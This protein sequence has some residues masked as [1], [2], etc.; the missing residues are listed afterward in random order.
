MSIRLGL[1][2]VLA[3]QVELGFFQ[4]LWVLELVSVLADIPRPHIQ[5]VN[6]PTHEWI[7]GNTRLYYYSVLLCPVVSSIDHTVSPNG[8]FSSDNCFWSTGGYYPLPTDTILRVCYG[9]EPLEALELTLFPSRMV[10]HAII[11]RWGNHQSR[12][13]VV[14]ANAKRSRRVR[15]DNRVPV[16]D[17]ETKRFALDTP[18]MKR[19]SPGI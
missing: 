5:Q 8:G 4:E 2:S 9:V 11:R 17:I 13:Y 16:P 1:A 12:A 19:S 7:A 15:P 3:G 6:C 10:A 14:R 18:T